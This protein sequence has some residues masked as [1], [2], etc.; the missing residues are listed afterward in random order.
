MFN[1]NNL[2]MRDAATWNEYDKHKREHVTAYREISVYKNF[3][4]LITT[5]YNSTKPTKHQN[6]F[7][8]RHIQGVPA[9]ERQDFENDE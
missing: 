7:S 6:S 9:V 4:R 5:K 2:L 1:S 3:K 8:G